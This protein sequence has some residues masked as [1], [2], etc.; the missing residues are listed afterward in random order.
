MTLVTLLIV[1]IL[2][3]VGHETAHVLTTLACGGRF[4]GIVVRHILA[5]GVKIRVDGL[6]AR[7]VMATLIAA[8]VAEMA[9]I[10]IASWGDPA[11]MGWWLFL[12]AGQIGASWIPW[13]GFP[14]D[15]QRF[16]ALLQQGRAA[17]ET[18]N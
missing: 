17:L 14:N 2:L 12:G 8:P 7:Q 13:W 11:G 1:A 16:F 10:A 18:D 3:V 6:S 15:G 9:I 4:E 5:V